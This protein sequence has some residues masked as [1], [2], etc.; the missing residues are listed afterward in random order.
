MNKKI[1]LIIIV[2]TTAS[3]KSELGV[4]LARKFNGEIISADSR[5]VYRNLD[6]GTAKIK[7]KWKNNMFL[8]KKVPHF[9][10]D[11]VS[12]KS[13]YT[14]ATFK[15][16]AQC[17]IKAIIARR[18]IPIIVGGT[19]FWIDALVYDIDLPHV[20]PNF[21][22]RNQLEKKSTHQLFA[23]LKKIDPRRAAH[24]E[25][26]NPRR[27]IRAIEIVKTLGCVPPMTRH[28]PYHTLW[29]GISR[30]DA[31]LRRSITARAHLMIKQGLVK[32]TKKLLVARVNKKRIHEF[33]FE[34]VAAL[35]VV[36]K[37]LTSNQLR[38]ILIRET[39]LYAKRQMRWFSRNKNI[40]WVSSPAKAEQLV[41][42][43]I[44]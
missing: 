18:N 14:A 10:I 27:L 2:G 42:T 21:P 35:S 12:P 8:Y 24:I 43:F 13:I 28:N 9:C 1:S 20:H 37:K 26:K 5:Q 41:R 15:K 30:D 33:G 17:A 11:I 16:H 40:Q 31:A 32:E 22:L 34:Y 25:Q 3:G 19:G 38:K 7:G 44:K 4:R 6:I 39:I 23:L 36:E 29:I